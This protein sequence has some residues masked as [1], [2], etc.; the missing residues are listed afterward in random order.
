MLFRSTLNV[1]HDSFFLSEYQV[2]NIFLS[3]VGLVGKNLIEQIKKQQD[4]LLKHNALNLRIVGISNS[5]KCVFKRE[6]IDL[7]NWEETLNESELPSTPEFLRDEMIRM[8]IFNPV[9]VDCTASAAVAAIYNELLQ[10]NINV[11]TANKIAASSSYEN[12][13]ELKEI[14]RKKGVKFLFE[15]NVGAGLPIINTINNLI[16]SGDEIL[17]IEAEIGRAH[18]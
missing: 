11:V 2:L 12:Y 5:R 17:K 18:V 14:S 6:G 8:N 4:N 7:E 10:H 13:A 16:N 1:I 3:G 15:T 9:F